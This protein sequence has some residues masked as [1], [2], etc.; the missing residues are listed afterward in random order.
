MVMNLLQACEEQESKSGSCGE[1]SMGSIQEELTA[2]FRKAVEA[3]FPDVP[4]VNVPVV[5]SPKFGDYQCNAAMQLSQLLKGQGIVILGIVTC[6]K[7]IELVG[8]YLMSST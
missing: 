2:L 4:D 3:A 8:W 1:V 5:P 7:H 6:T